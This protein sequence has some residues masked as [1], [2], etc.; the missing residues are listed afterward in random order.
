SRAAT[1]AFRW[2]RNSGMEDLGVLPGR[3]ESTA[4]GINDAGQVV[5]YSSGAAGTRAFLW[6]GRG[7]MEDLGTLPGGDFSRALAINDDNE[8]VGASGSS[9]GTRAALWTRDGDIQDLNTLIP[10]SHNFVLTQAVSN[11]NRGMILA[12]GHDDDGS[13]ERNDDHESPT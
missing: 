5:G 3:T 11:N 9:L 10:A 12:I 13:G 7:R 1:R 8:I 4:T 2:T 6:T